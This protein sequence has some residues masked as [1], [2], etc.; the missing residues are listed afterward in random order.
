MLILNSL[1]YGK[2]NHI[3]IFSF[4]FKKFM[5]YIFNLGWNLRQDHL[6]KYIKLIQK[7]QLK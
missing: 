5:D 3:L 4:K 7:R 1:L 6:N 2:N